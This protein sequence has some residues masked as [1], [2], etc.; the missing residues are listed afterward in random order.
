LKAKEYIL[1]KQINW[2]QNQGIRLI[3]SKGNRGRPAYTAT[4]DENLFEP[5][6]P[7]VRYYFQCADG[8]E[9]LSK[10]GNPAKMHA[11]H[12]SSALGVNVFQYWERTDQVPIIAAAC[13]FCRSDSTVSVRIVFEE[14]FT[15]DP[16]FR[17]SP[18]V[19]VVIHNTQSRKYKAFAIECK[20][21]EAYGGHGHG[22][23]KQPYLE[24]QELWEDIPTLRLLAESISPMDDQYHYLHP[25]Q[26]IKH[27]LGLKRQFG[28]GGFRL[29]YLW[30]DVLGQ[31]GAVHRK[32][33][34]NFTGFSKAKLSKIIRNL[35]YQN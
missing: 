26:L 4:L 5:L 9:I 13:G 30:Y 1:A 7:F 12:S 15:I 11:V 29:L 14:K 31:E 35:E 3:G 21:A 28:K 27:I 22:G 16:K 25:A 8:S 19:D 2:A 34:E 32:E 17:Y 18:N 20:F 10:H 6:E 23:L 24:L 33:I